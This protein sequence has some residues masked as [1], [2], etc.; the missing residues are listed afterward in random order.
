MKIDKDYMS[1]PT[2]MG[3][4]CS[5]FTFVI[6]S[7][8]AFQKTDILLNRLDTNLIGAT[9][10]N[11]FDS[12]FVFDYSR[13]FNF[14]VALTAFNSNQE[15]ILDPSYGELRFRA[16]SWGRDPVTDESF[17]G[18]EPVPSHPCSREE[19]GLEGEAQSRFFPTTADSASDVSFYSKKFVCIDDENLKVFGD[20]NS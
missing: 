7:G 8:Y 16:Y 6:I 12:D 1:L 10:D 3:T 18:E 4:L 2:W 15:H 5:I 11:N 14:A 19:L 17:V 20:Y 9:I 13:G